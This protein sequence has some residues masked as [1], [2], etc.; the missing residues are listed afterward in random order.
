M[1]TRSNSIFRPH[2]GRWGAAACC[3][4]LSACTRQNVPAQSD[5]AR[6][7]LETALSTWKAGE[8]PSG[9]AQQ[10]PP[11]VVG[12]FAW[13]SGKKLAAYRLPDEAANDG[14]N[15]H[16]AVELT[17]ADQQGR[18]TSQ[19]VSYVVSTHPTITIFRD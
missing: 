4:L 16:Y 9:L 11:I 14:V 10:T 19:V 1:R 2:L 15:L 13:E 5:L 6:Q 17:F 18:P 8:P 3:L 7:S 12:D